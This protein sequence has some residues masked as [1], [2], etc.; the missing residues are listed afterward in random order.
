MSV[1]RV[2]SNSKY[3]DGWSNVFGSSKASAGKTAAKASKK[4]AK[5]RTKKAVKKKVAVSKK[6]R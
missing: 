5:K 1:I 6:K 4:S 3:A 2:G